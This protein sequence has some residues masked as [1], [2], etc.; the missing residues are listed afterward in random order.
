[1]SLLYTYNPTR[2]RQTIPVSLRNILNPQIGPIPNCFVILFSL[3]NFICQLFKAD[4]AVRLFSNKYFVKEIFQ[5]TTIGLYS[6]HFTIASLTVPTLDWQM[7]YVGQGTYD[8]FL[9]D[10]SSLNT[11]PAHFPRSSPSILGWS[12]RAQKSCGILGVVRFLIRPQ[13]EMT[14]TQ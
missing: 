10:F 13:M 1:M 4:S 14:L 8:N 11:F 7:C 2:Q 5:F 3:P 12:L 6:K 9:L